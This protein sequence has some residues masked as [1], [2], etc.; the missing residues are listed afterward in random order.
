VKIDFMNLVGGLMCTGKTRGW[1]HPRATPTKLGWEM[2]REKRG[3]VT[4]P[5]QEPP[6]IVVADLSNTAESVELSL[7]PQAMGG[8]FRTH[9]ANFDPPAFDPCDFSVLL[10]GALCAGG[11]AGGCQA[12]HGGPEN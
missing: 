2:A 9:D 8:S 12:S 10:D 1:L 11:R 6:S 4:F 5:S 3:P 7:P